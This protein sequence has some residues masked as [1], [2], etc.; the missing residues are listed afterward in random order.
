MQPMPG[1]SLSPQSCASLRRCA[2]KTQ[3]LLRM[4]AFPW[5]G[6]GASVY[7]KLALCLPPHIELLAVQLPG[8]EDRFGESLMVRMEQI[9][10][11]TLKDIVSVFDRPLILFGHSMGALVAWE[12]AQALR[13]RIGREPTALIVSGHGAPHCAPRSTRSWHSA[14]ERDLI[15]NIRQ[16]GGTPNELLEDRPMMRAFMP[17]LRADYEVVENYRPKSR[18]PLSCS[19]VACA[20]GEDREVTPETMR[21]WLSCTTGHRRLHWF[22]GD[23]FYLSSQPAL[24]ARSIEEWIAPSFPMAPGTGFDQRFGK[25][26]A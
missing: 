7:R 22:E 24:L 26:M 23:H 20:G 9:V 2:P 6:A 1:R 13:D 15:A 25:D 12:I 8:R 5:C 3:P 17:L 14:N 21:A 4:L 18:P 10:E 19:L 16:L 11:H